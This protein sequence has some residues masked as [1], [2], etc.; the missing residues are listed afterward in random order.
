MIIYLVRDTDP[1]G[2]YLS[3][4]ADRPVLAGREAMFVDEIRVVDEFP[5]DVWELAIQGGLP[6]DPGG[7]GHDLAWMPWWEEGQVIWKKDA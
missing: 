6:V 5:E 7:I 3:A 4:Q 1:D 2:G